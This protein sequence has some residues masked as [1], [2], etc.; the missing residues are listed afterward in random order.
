[1]TFFLKEI[2]NLE[3]HQNRI[4]GSRVT[5]I[6]LKKREFFLS[7][8]VVKLVGG[9]SVINGAQPV[10]FK[11]NRSFMCHLIFVNTKQFMLFFYL[12]PKSGKFWMFVVKS[13]KLAKCSINAWCVMCIV[14]C[15]VQSVWV[16]LHLQLQV[17][18]VVFT[19]QSVGCKV[20][21]TPIEDLEVER[22][23]FK[24]KIY[25]IQ[26]LFKSLLPQCIFLSVLRLYILEN[27]N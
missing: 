5:A 17:K 13:D 12:Q 2:L 23:F 9:G 7:D 24:L 10:Q 21:P 20:M 3:G 1:M 18:C 6:W 4:T 26:L 14:Q 15:V 11:R 8:K 25:L 22:G 19:V 27:I 16:H